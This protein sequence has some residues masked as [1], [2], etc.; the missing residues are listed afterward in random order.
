MISRCFKFTVKPMGLSENVPCTPLYPMVCLIIIPTK[1]LFY[2]GFGPHFQTYPYSNLG[3]PLPTNCPKHQ[4]TGWGSA[5]RKESPNRVEPVP[6]SPQKSRGSPT[7]V[8]MKHAVHGLFGAPL[9]W[10]FF[11]RKR[12]KCGS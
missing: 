6:V 4:G 11:G 2:W 9:F 3:F 7:S 8:A 1:W 12:S 10:H 5:P